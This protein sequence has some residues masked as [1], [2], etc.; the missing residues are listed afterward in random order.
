[1]PAGGAARGAAPRGAGALGV[2]LGP[3]AP[4][5]LATVVPDDA[6]L[7]ALLADREIPVRERVAIAFA[8]PAFQW[9]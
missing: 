9:R 8:S 2:G 3:D 7:G 4:S 6:A 1:M 5:A